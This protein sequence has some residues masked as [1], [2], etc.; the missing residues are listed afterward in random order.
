[1][2]KSTQFPRSTVSSFP[3][4]AWRCAALSPSASGF[5]DSVLVSPH[6]K[7][8]EE[9]QKHVLDSSNPVL[10]DADLYAPYGE[11]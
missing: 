1:M 4:D 3:P 8:G 9:T 10:S 2:E 5:N 7:T 11:A 6:E